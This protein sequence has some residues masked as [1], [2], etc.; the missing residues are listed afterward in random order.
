MSAF[1]RISLP[2]LVVVTGPPGSGK[3]T[4]ARELARRIGCPAICRDDIKQGMAHANPGFAPAPG[5]DL[6]RRTLPTFFAVLEVLLSAGVSTVAEAAFADRVWQQGLEPFRRCA[7]LRIVH[8][9]VNAETA[10]RRC[11]R[12]KA[13]DPAR[14]AHADPGPEDS[15]EQRRRHEAFER[16]SLDEPW[17]EVDTT[18]GYH[19]GL[20]ELMTFINS[21][22]T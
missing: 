6:T 5:D 22:S 10:Q 11:L 17:I 13:E 21:R 1:I 20:A 4:L 3:T 9:T 7:R 16:L 8:C 14:A 19:P 15:A 12:R 2:A 18:D